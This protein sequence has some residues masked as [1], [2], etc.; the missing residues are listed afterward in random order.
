M[1]R[2]RNSASSGAGCKRSRHRMRKTCR[3]PEAAP[4]MAREREARASFGQ[5]VLIG[6]APLAAADHGWIDRAC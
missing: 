1:M 5:W 4:E 3:C 2:A 6:F